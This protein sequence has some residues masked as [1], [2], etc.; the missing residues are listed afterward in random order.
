MNVLGMFVKRAAPGQVKTRLAASIG[1]VA[2]ARVYEA[3][4]ETLLARLASAGQQRLLAVSPDEAVAH[5]SRQIP[6][7]PWQVVPQGAGDLGARMARF[8]AQ[9]DG[10][11]QRRV[12]VGSDC[13]QLSPQAVEEA[14]ELLRSKRV[15]LG[16][17]EDGG[18]YL[19]GLSGETPDLFLDM[20]WSTTDVLALT[21]DRLR[22]A[23]IEPALLARQFD[24]DVADD[25]ARLR[26]ELSQSRDPHLVRLA[27]RL[28]EILGARG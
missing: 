17:A 26:G 4:V 1:P 24:V 21:L 7:S 19:I 14:F 27:Q 20:P 22:T 8:F 13:P 25:L 18:Y 2:A 12:L 10:A 3:F 28:D 16:P 5:F 15:V 6:A 9:D 11:S 23:G